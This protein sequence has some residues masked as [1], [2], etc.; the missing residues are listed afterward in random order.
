MSP[1]LSQMSRPRTGVPSRPELH[2]SDELLRQFAANIDKVVW[3]SDTTLRRLLYVN[4][5]YEQIWG[6][7]VEALLRAPEQFIESIH[8]DDRARVAESIER[9]RRGEPTETIYR[10]VRPDGS[11]RWIR[12][13]SFPIL[14]GAGSVYRVAGIAEDITDNRRDQELLAMQRRVLEAL[15]LSENLQQ[16]PS[17]ICLEIEQMLPGVICAIHR[18]EARTVSLVAA[19]SASPEV[20]AWLGEAA[21]GPWQSA[22]GSG[23]RVHRPGTLTG[24]ATAEGFR[25]CW[26]APLE[27]AN[28]TVAGAFT[29]LCPLVGEPGPEVIAILDSA[30]DL[31][32]I[33]IDRLHAEARQRLMVRE[34]DHRV[35]NNLASVMSLAQQTAASADSIDAF[36]PALFGRITSLAIA[37]EQLAQSKWDG[38][39]LASM[40]R[41]IAGSL[42]AISPERLAM[43]GPPVLLCPNMAPALS[44]VIHEL[45][46]NAA[47]H[48]ALSHPA[49]RVTMIWQCRDHEEGQR[50]T[51]E[52]VELGGPP[53]S[54]E[55]TQGLGMKLI[56]G[57]VESQLRGSVAF[58]FNPGGLECSIELPRDLLS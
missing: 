18:A 16:I 35:K 46:V 15:A 37:H 6:R 23:E 22:I 45:A 9:H 30:T 33:T 25:S 14:D 27:S 13:S 5:A 10:I 4:G 48:G 43:E 8:T 24:P 36:L 1:D 55:P 28:H 31:S 11:I 17:A 3:M 39:N 50:L 20:R 47:K 38:A 29:V 21:D 51:I 40:A 49:G 42:T 34:L 7:P 53:V 57:L 26:S 44:M 41:Q 56:H 2:A 52:W 54:Q 19:P 32:E 12:D 58:R